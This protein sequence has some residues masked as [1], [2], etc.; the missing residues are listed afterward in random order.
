MYNQ[1]LLLE[2]GI[3]ESFDAIMK[4]AKEDFQSQTL[5]TLIELIDSLDHNH[6][7]I[8]SALIDAQL[9]IQKA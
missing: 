9:K 2:Y 6:L 4:E 1:N 7:K 5:F 8:A 3:T